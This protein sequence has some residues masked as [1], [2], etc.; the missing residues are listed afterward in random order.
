MHAP[1]RGLL[2]EMVSQDIPHARPLAPGHRTLG[3]LG[4]SSMDLFSTA[5]LNGLLGVG[6]RFIELL[7]IKRDGS[8]YDQKE[9]ESRLHERE[10]AVAAEQQS[11]SSA[12]SDW[13]GLEIQLATLSQTDRLSKLLAANPFRLSPE[14]AKEVAW[15]A[16]DGGGKPIILEAPIGI[17]GRMLGADDDQLLEL[18]VADRWSRHP[19]STDAAPLGGL[20]DRPLKNQDLDIHMIA[21]SLSSIP[22]I[23]VYGYVRSDRSLWLSACAWN[24]ITRE[25]RSE[26]LKIALPGIP[27]PAFDGDQVA[28]QRWKDEI[29]TRSTTIIAFLTQWFHLVRYNRK[30]TLER[31][32]EVGGGQEIRRLIASQLIP[33]Y[34]VI[35]SYGDANYDLRIDQAELFAAAGM[36]AR[37]SVFSLSILDLIRKQRSED[38]D[39]ETLGRL[40]A[41]L[42]IVGD[43]AS[44]N[45]V[46][47]LAEDRSK[48]AVERVLGWVS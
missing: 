10:A 13:R 24:V 6:D 4:E 32:A 29:A 40:E 11:V 5:A 15:Q 28:L 33:A 12:A 47:E 30:P 45:E 3:R 26:Q 22:V 14:D 42:E 19:C 18:N 38:T 20:I 23:L 8:F 39:Y 9:F 34:E 44:A 35:A 2:V 41:L 31:L 27:L 17:S 21:N 7:K 48:L 25:S 1:R 46:K 16:S 36:N 43:T 37:A